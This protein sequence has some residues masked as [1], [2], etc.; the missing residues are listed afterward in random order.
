M[1]SLLHFP[2]NNEFLF[3]INYSVF[4]FCTLHPDP[5]PSLS[6]PLFPVLTLQILTPYTFPFPSQKGKPSLGY[7]CTLGHL[8]PAGLSKSSS[9]ETQAGSPVRERNPVAENSN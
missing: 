3:L 4:F 9:T 5:S 8:L 7:H 6:C 2:L 1:K